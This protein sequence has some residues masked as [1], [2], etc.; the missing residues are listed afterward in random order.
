MSIHHKKKLNPSCTKKLVFVTEFVIL[1]EKRS[2][3]EVNQY[4]SREMSMCM[5]GFQKNQPYSIFTRSLVVEWLTY[6]MLNA[7]YKIKIRM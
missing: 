6:N 7:K 4:I 3:S 2:C 1:E 5:E